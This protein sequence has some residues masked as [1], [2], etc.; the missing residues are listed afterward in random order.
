MRLL[1]RTTFIGINIQDP[2]NDVVAVA[3][4]ALVALTAVLIPARRALGI[5]PAAALRHE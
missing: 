2:V 4:T 3:I 5:D 1:I